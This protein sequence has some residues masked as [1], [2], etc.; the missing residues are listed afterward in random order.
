MTT[1]II[2]SY[3][4]LSSFHYNSRAIA[5]GDVLEI[6]GDIDATGHNGQVGIIARGTADAPVTIRGSGTIRGPGLRIIGH[7]VRVEGLT[8]KGATW[9]GLNISAWSQLENLK[10]E[11]VTV[12]NCTFVDCAAGVW[13]EKAAKVR[14]EGCKFRDL[15]M[16]VA[17]TEHSDNDFGANAVHVT[18]AQGVTVVDC[19]AVNLNAPSPDYGTDGGFLE[20]YG[21]VSD[22][23][24]SGNI[25]YD[26]ITL[27]ESGGMNSNE[28]HRVTVNDNV[29]YL[30][31]ETRSSSKQRY[32][33]HTPLAGGQYRLGAMS[34]FVLKDNTFYN[35]SSDY[36]PGKSRLSSEQLVMSGDTNRTETLS[37][38][39]FMERHTG[40]TAPLP[41][42]VKTEPPVEPQPP[43]EPAVSTARTITLKLMATDAAGNT[44]ALADADATLKFTSDTLTE[45][46]A[47]LLEWWRNVP[48]ELATAHRHL[49]EG[50]YY[51]AIAALATYASQTNGA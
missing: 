39:A 14:V 48:G 35:F 47:A 29:I 17:D 9:G 11:H 16:N 44:L 21:N 18:K 27:F 12:K 6:R 46:E 38:A 25:C 37:E 4:K 33:I 5:A 36:I 45:S 31:A 42:T 19:V 23:T 40:E 10:V 20:L 51:A 8:L 1:H 13:I 26:V 32:T 15:R 43:T 24:C 22:V 41:P 49:Q 3:N 7:H 28:Q 30:S 50:D 2:D 34:G